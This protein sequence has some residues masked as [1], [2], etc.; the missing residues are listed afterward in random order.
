MDSITSAR[1]IKAEIA[2]AGYSLARAGELRIPDELWQAW[3]SLSIDY[4][5]LPADEYLPG[6]G[7]YL[8]RRYGRLAFSPASGALTRLPYED[9]FQSAEINPVTGGYLRK[10]APLLD[11]TFENEFLRE[12]IRFDFRQFP[13]AE[14]MIDGDWE[15]HA[16]LIR[17]KADKEEQ[18][19]PTPEGVHRDGAEFVT[20]HLAELVN[21]GG[22]DVSIYD[23]DRN[24]LTAFRL[25]Q[26][27]DSYL[28]HDADL[29][30]AAE[31]IRPVDPSHGAIRSI[32]TFD[33][34]PP[35]GSV[36]AE[37]S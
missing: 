31:P 29:W 23:D 20:V 15:V 11:S 33:F 27:M 7:R 1:K 25:E 16:H 4:S 10:F 32:L 14:T 13:L 6:G 35:S 12:L 24:L 17:V 22:G 18:G 36:H 19:Q 34:H 9:Y 8:F 28:F 21:A 2:A 30:H 37:P 3:L 26:V 5:D